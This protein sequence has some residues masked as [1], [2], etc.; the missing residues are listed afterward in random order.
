M[1]IRHGESVRNKVKG[2]NIYFPDDES[3]AE[4]K[5]TPD[6]KVLLTQEGIR[7]AYA[8]GRH[9]KDNY[10]VPDC[11]YHSGYS[12]TVQ[13]AMGICY[14]YPEHLRRHIKVQVDP[15]I[16][17][18]HPGYCYDMTTTEAETH[19]PWL[20]EYWKTFGGFLAQPPGGES[21][22]EVANRVQ[23]FLNKI[24]QDHAGQNVFV[25]THGGT[26]R[27]FRFLL[28]QWSY[29]RARSWGAGQAPKNCGVTDYTYSQEEGRLMLGTYNR[30][31]Y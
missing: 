25:V 26:L 4:V 29:E 18:R 22:A 23:I 20:S 8:T 11:I 19:F 15:F 17:E 1:I 30:V 24:D 27:A 2:H 31:F 10:G 16:R 28:E 9:M 14:G 21:L 12:R 6:N 5:G 13:T 3:R 7:Q